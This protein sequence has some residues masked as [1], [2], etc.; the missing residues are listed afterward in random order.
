MNAPAGAGLAR[1]EGY[2]LRYFLVTSHLRHFLYS[3]LLLIL[4]ETAYLV[5]GVVLAA[6]TG[7]GVQA[8][9]L[10]SSLTLGLYLSSQIILVLIKGFSLVWRVRLIAELIGDRLRPAGSPSAAGVTGRFQAYEEAKEAL[11]AAN[12][13]NDFVSSFFVFLIFAGC[14]CALLVEILSNGR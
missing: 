7:L 12:A 10:L 1:L 8:M 2:L 14:A 5:V 4:L 11:P 3:S 13:W 9:I 6:A